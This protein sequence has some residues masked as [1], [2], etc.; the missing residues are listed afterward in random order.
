M[1]PHWF[2]RLMI[3]PFLPLFA[4]EALK[5]KKNGAKLSGFPEHFNLGQGR[6]K[7]IILGE[8]TVAGV[9][10]SSIE[11]TLSGNLSTLLG[12]DFEVENLGKNGLTLK[13]SIFFFKKHKKEPNSKTTGFFLF[14]GAN[15]CFRLTD[16]KEFHKELRT[17]I[18]FLSK[19]YSPAWIYLADI[20][21]VHIFPAFSSLLRYFMKI[22]RSHLQAEMLW[23]SKESRIIIFDPISI[24]IDQNFFSIDQIH[25]SDI[26]YRKMAEFA[27]KKI[28]GDGW[29]KK[30]HYQG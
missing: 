20:P 19:E 28:Q 26:G 24:P 10:A 22:Q 5:I 1:M 27:I 4:F 7:I 23:C 6:K 13:N 17:L 16:P 18:S 30:E 21:P 12:K 14:F 3:Y 8:S 15:D 9:G 29:L 2:F 11:H 25:P